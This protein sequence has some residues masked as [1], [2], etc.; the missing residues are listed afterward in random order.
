[1]RLTSWLTALRRGR[2][3]ARRH[4]RTLRS[5]RTHRARN[6]RPISAEVLEDRTL[7]SVTS[8]FI[9]G[10]L[11]I[12]SDADDDIAISADLAG[13]V[14]VTANG[15]VQTVAPPVSEAGRPPARPVGAGGGVAS[16]RSRHGAGR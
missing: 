4:N 1:M 3:L 16:R 13:Q 9:D 10:E 11:S 6:P 12:V 8:L 7:L 2:R 15:I 14:V 5:A